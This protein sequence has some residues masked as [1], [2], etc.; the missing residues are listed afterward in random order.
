MVSVAAAFLL[1]V[2]AARA[3]GETNVTPI[4]AMG[5]ITQL[6]FGVLLPGNAAANLMT[7]TVTAGAASHSAD[8]LMEVKTGYLLGGAPRKQFWA[9]LLGVLAGAIVCVP[10]YFV[11]ARPEKIGKELAAPAAIAWA[12]VAK[13]LKDGAGNLPK[14]ALPAIGVAA[15]VGVVLAVF[16]ELAARATARATAAGAK[17]GPGWTAFV[18]SA[19]GLGIAMVIDFHDSFAMFVGAAIAWWLKARH[20]AANERYTVSV[21]SGLVAG[22]GLMGIVVIVLRDVLGWLK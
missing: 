19:T 14:L 12:S 11:V 9:Q 22:E 5:K 13:L 16:D 15:A 20:P 4:G 21:A 8:L 18:P 7:A 2:V 3:T 1:S 10:V 17:E 6:L